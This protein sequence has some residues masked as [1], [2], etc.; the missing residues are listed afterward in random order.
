M[1]VWNEEKEYLISNMSLE[2]FFGKYLTTI[3]NLQILKEWHTCC[4]FREAALYFERQKK[5]FCIL[6]IDF[7]SVFKRMLLQPFSNFTLLEIYPLM[8]LH[9]SVKK[10]VYRVYH[11]HTYY[12]LC[13]TSRSIDCFKTE[14]TWRFPVQQLSSI[15]FPDTYWYIFVNIPV[16][17]CWLL[18]HS[19]NRC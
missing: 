8:I 10:I 14:I 9:I 3:M 17:R 6:N 15:Y 13:D 19:M 18:N 11:R 4:I 12:V 16:S 5:L 2:I 7:E 1:N